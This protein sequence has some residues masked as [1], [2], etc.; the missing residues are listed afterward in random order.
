MLK[1]NQEANSQAVYK[2]IYDLYLQHAVDAIE[3]RHYLRALKLY[4]GMVNDLSDRYGVSKPTRLP[5]EP[6][7]R[8]TA[9]AA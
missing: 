3:R 6:I 1:I 5:I 4:E 9:L 7:N 2:G 8:Y